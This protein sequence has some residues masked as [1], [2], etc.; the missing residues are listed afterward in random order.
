MGFQGAGSHEGVVAN[1]A[2]VRPLVGVLPFVVSEM[3]LGGEGTASYGSSTFHSLS[4]FCRSGRSQMV[5]LLY[6]LT[7]AFKDVLSL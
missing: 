7:H 5:S 6:G 1:L 4:I 3:A 2:H